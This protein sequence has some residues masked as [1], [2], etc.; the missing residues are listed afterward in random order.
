MKFIKSNSLTVTFIFII[1]VT[2]SSLAE[3]SKSFKE[4]LRDINIVINAPVD[5][6]ENEIKQFCPNSGNDTRDILSCLGDHEDSLSNDCKKSALA[7]SL[8][9]VEAGMKLDEAIN[10]CHIDIDTFCSETELGQN[11][12]IPCLR[13]HQKEI[14][15]QCYSSL[16]AAQFWDPNYKGIWKVGE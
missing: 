14:S 6:C 10:A 13:E 2:S 9:I 15:K 16:E 7:T 12:I 4:K 1:G 3:E 5:G 8:F 11:R